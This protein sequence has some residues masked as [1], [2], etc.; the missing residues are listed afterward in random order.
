M[1]Q[2]QNAPTTL[3]AQVSKTAAFDGSSVDI[4]AMPA[5]PGMIVV[6]VKIDSLTANK[7]AV[8]ALE[9]SAD[10]FSSDIRTLATFH[11]KGAIQTIAPREKEF[12]TWDMPAV[13]YGVTS[14]HMRLSLISID[15]SATVV[16][17]AFIQF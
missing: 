15:G 16:Y 12:H 7:T 13:R 4:S 10:G 8:F 9:D 14:A 1:S 6:R 11:V 5:E 2:V 17:E 3:Q